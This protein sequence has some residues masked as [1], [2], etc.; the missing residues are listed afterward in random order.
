[1]GLGHLSIRSQE[2]ESADSPNMPPV[3]QSSIQV[4]QQME[5]EDEDD[6]ENVDPLCS[7]EQTVRASSSPPHTAKKNT[8]D[9]VPLPSGDA[10]SPPILPDD[11]GPLSGFMTLAELGL[12]GGS[13]APSLSR[14][15]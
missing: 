10:M 15:H 12:L 2:P 5:S 14:G 6:Q 1:L 8:H 11:D 7:W 4:D 9:R 13:G 3:P